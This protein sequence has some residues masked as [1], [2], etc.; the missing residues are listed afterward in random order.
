[1]KSKCLY[2]CFLIVLGL[3]FICVSFAVKS[4]LLNHY[5]Y[6]D[7]YAWDEIID[8][9]N[10][11]VRAA[12]KDLYLFRKPRGI[13]YYSVLIAGV[14][15]VS[16][17]LKNVIRLYN[18]KHTDTNVDDRN[19]DIYVPPV[20]KKS[21]Y[22]ENVT[23]NINAMDKK[24]KAVGNGEAFYVT[25][26]RGKN[27]S[28]NLNLEINGEVTKI[29]YINSNKTVTLPAGSHNFLLYTDKHET[30]FVL[31]V[32]Y[33]LDVYVNTKRKKPVLERVVNTK[34]YSK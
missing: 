18:G 6:Y 5:E 22:A 14:L 4:S 16:S 31:N 29:L 28:D 10:T 19:G 33:N 20:P 12:K 1:M 34:Q 7:E 24:S 15:G 32:Y 23:F 25:F 3:G 9:K 26:I 13:Y 21:P 11:I 2:Y 17:G 27:D 30:R 8:I